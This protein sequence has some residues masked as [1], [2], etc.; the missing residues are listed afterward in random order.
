MS[1][2]SDPLLP[3]THKAVY[4]S[5]IPAPYLHLWDTK[6]RRGQQNVPVTTKLIYADKMIDKLEYLF[7]NFRIRI[8]HNIFF[9]IL[10]WFPK[11]F[12]ILYFEFL[13]FRD[14]I[15]R[16]RFFRDLFFEILSF[17]NFVFRDLFF[18]VFSF[19]IFIFEI[20]IVIRSVGRAWDS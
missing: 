2:D 16:K 15:F 17:R 3:V 6:S 18:E 5:L 9:P 10:W 11:F 1:V 4:P 8:L 7:R 19:E 13:L 20:L 12:Y 14:F